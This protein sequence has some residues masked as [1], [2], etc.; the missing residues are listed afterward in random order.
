MKI[1]TETE[2]ARSGTAFQPQGRADKTS[3][4][5]GGVYNFVMTPQGWYL[6]RT[7]DK[8]TF[9]FKVYGAS[10]D[11]INRVIKYWE[12]NGGNLGVLMNGL[13]GAGKTM[14]S[15]I[16]ANDLIESQNLPVLVVRGP[17]P[18]QAIFDSVQQDMM[19]IFDEFEKTHQDVEQQALLSTIDG[20]SRSVHNRLI[21]F[22]TN[23]PTINE[24]FRDR[25]SRIHYQFQFDRVADEVI[26][27]LIEDGLPENLKHFKP[28]ILEFLNSR[29]ICTID[30]VKATIAEVKTFEESPR[31]FE[32]ILNVSKGTP[33]AFK[34][35]IL[36]EQ[37]QPIRVFNEFFR[38]HHP[39]LGTLLAGSHKK[40]QE[41]MEQRGGAGVQAVSRNF[42]GS[43]AIHLLEKTEEE[44]CWLANLSLPKSKTYL[45]ELKGEDYDD[46]GYYIFLDSRPTGW[47]RPESR[48]D[49]E[50]AYTTAIN[51]GTLHGTG[52]RAVFKI[53]VECNH[54]RNYTIP[55]QWKVTAGAHSEF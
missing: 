34:V 21:L 38:P 18:L 1:S 40:A 43:Y 6:D 47:K 50:E 26:E 49:L 13:R 28:D 41:Y 42:D 9:P 39:S 33:P 17:I 25:P 19:V 24:N 46:D 29:N 36:D 8:F 55:S 7:S 48:K 11:I 54:I 52:R 30:I 51:T 15:Q 23:T 12:V 53:R 27:G 4:L 14:T 2:W 20:M 3:R 16:L 35:E 32:N 5:P 31:L 45:S 44:G 10:T 37:N 22:T